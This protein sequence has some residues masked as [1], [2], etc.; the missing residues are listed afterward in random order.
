MSFI[1]V[2][3]EVLNGFEGGCV[4]D[5]EGQEVSERGDG[6]SEVISFQGVVYFFFYIQFLFY[7]LCMF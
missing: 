2:Y 6:D 4:I 3:I 1:C 7:C 5:E